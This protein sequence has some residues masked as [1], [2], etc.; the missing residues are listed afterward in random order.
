MGFLDKIKENIQETA[1]MAREGIGDLQTKRE[2]GQAYG[3]LGRK[4]FDLI[5]SGPLQA[6]QLQAEVDAVR[7]LKQQLEEEEEKA[8]GESAS[9]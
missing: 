2:L 1:T 7:K 4:A 9:G 6:P 3:E 5:E 8:A